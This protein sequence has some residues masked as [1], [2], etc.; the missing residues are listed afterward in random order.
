MNIDKSSMQ[1]ELIQDLHQLASISS[2]W[3]CLW[4]DVP[5]ADLFLGREWFS[6]W[7]HNFSEATDSVALHVTSG[8]RVIHF[9]PRQ[10]RPNILLVRAQGVCVA[11]LPLLYFSDSWRNLPARILLSPLNGQSW[12]SGV[13]T[14]ESDS[15][16]VL[17]TL[18]R[19]LKAQADWDVLLMDGVPVE[20]A[21]I[22]NLRSA[23]C[24]QG[25]W[26]SRADF[27][28][29]HSYLALNGSW[30]EYVQAKGKHFRKHMRQAEGYLAQLG[31]LSF[32]CYR[33]DADRE[34]GLQIFLEIDQS[35]W[36]AVSGE[37]VAAIPALTGFYSDLY[38]QM[39][40]QGTCEI[41]V[42]RI[43][44][45]PVSAVFCMNSRGTLY[46]YKTS[47]K[48]QYTS[49]KLSPG[50]ILLTHL[51]KQGYG[52]G[53]NEVDF[54]SDMPITHRWTSTAHEFARTSIY[55]AHYYGKLLFIVDYLAR[56]LRP[57]FGQIKGRVWDGLK[58]VNGFLTRSI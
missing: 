55:A 57:L 23:A 38:R 29:R 33:A 40:Q 22:A 19:Y 7:W 26:V 53:L 50:M 34:M 56:W 41:W 31:E 2:E 25:L 46:A 4:A 35:S 28:W 39:H 12:R 49:A 47:S 51:I 37:S 9:Q 18:M 52:V 3:D 15:A 16:A 44:Q 21:V 1:V 58:G 27:P 17:D 14:A 11:I 45:T 20:S 6:I 43:G 5:S 54:L 30:D 10:L 48:E 24:A 32:E 13:L 42:L 8:Y 36:K